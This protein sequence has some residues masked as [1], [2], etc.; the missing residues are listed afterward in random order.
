MLPSLNLLHESY[1]Q[2][3]KGII[4]E[5]LSKHSLRAAL[6]ASDGAARFVA[7]AVA[8]TKPAI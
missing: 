5:A 2:L 3:F 4:Q 1:K 8:P 6:D 7:P